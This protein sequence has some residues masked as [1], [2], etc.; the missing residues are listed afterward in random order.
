MEFYEESF[1]IELK[2]LLV[3]QKVNSKSSAGTGNRIT[4]MGT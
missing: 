2:F 3:C 4:L 1:E